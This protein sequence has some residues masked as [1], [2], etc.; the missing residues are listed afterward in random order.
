MTDDPGYVL[1]ASMDVEPDKEELFNQVYDEHAELLLAVPG[2][3]SVTR[4][5]GEEFKIAIGGEVKQMPAPNPVYTTIYEL[6]TSG[7]L[8]SDA[9][10]AAVEKGRWAS[11]VR[12]FT[13]NRS[14]SLF[15]KLKNAS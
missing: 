5:K 13:R 4:L 12:L 3:R 8:E 7:V 10:A 2:V 11:E 14:H 6:D 15:R 1:I 9:W